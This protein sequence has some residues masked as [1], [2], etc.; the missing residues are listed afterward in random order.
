MRLEDGFNDASAKNSMRVL[1]RFWFA[2]RVARDD[3]DGTVSLMKPGD[4]LH[5]ETPSSQ[6]FH[7]QERTPTGV[8]EEVGGGA[9]IER[10]AV[11]D[12]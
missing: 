3:K 9:L 2:P 12:Q 6:E 8:F 11:S 1:D 7:R 4:L 5:M 10:Y